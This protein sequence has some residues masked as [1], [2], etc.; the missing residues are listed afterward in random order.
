[1]L[2]ALLFAIGA[3]CVLIALWPFGPY[4]LTLIIARRLCSFSTDSRSRT[5][6]SRAE[7]RLLCYLRVRL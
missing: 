5:D 4:Q 6:C 3:V 1:M 2:P 7:R